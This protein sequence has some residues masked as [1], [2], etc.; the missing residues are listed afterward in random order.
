MFRRFVQL[1]RS[2]R[3]AGLNRARLRRVVASDSMGERTPVFFIFTPELVHFA[4]FCLSGVSPEFAPVLVLN[5]VDKDDE[6]WLQQQLPG[7]P[8]VRLVTSIS[9]N[10]ASM[11]AH[12]EVLNDLFAVCE[13]CFCIQDPDCFVIDDTFWNQVPIESNHFAGGPFV[14]RPTNH[15]HVLPDTFFL[16][17][18]SRVFRDVSHKYGVTANVIRSLGTGARQRLETIGYT[19]GDYPER[20]KGY[21]DTLQ[22]Y[23]LLSL[24]D[25]LTFKQMPGAGET[26]FHIGGTSY[27]HKTDYDLSHW[28]YWPLSV[29][30]F[31][32][33]LLERPGLARF[34]ERFK[35]VFSQHESADRLLHSYPEFKQTIRFSQTEKILSSF[36]P[37]I[38]ESGC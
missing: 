33:R 3:L 10:S 34:R 11:L 36:D 29:H 19:V 7:L 14:K 28:D 32:L 13:G 21:F 22:A 31:N 15:D 12:A 37:A 2:K 17:F 38:V 20:F 8:I 5:A 23:W 4:P 16:T 24:A 1:V 18:N 30:Y 26:V 35:A 6:H 27:M 9:G 25:G